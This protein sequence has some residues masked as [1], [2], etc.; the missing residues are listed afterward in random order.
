MRSLNF[1][2]PKIMGVINMTPDS[3]STNGRF[4][5]IDKAL[6][7]AQQMITDGV[8]I[9]DVGA[10]PTNPSLHPCVSLQEETDRLMPFLAKLC[11]NFDVPV[12]V[13][14]SKPEIMIEAIKQGVSIINDVRAFQREGAIAAV[15]DKNVMLCL[16]H[17]SY[18][19]G[20]PEGID[21]EN[22]NS[23]VT[24]K[25]KDFLAQR[26]EILEA[27]NIRRARLILD[28]GIGFGNFGKSTRDNLKLLNSIN[29]FK[30]FDLPVL[31]GVSR[32]TFIG[33]ILQNAPEDRLAGSIAAT[34]IAVYNGA[35]IIR[36]HD[37][38][39]TSEAVIIAEALRNERN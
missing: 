6:K 32:K 10:E 24:T 3:F 29:V 39:L 15:A 25:V 31:I 18:P 13:D 14:T 4:Q 23:D 30:D 1:R 16:M 33:D 34:A 5:N 28:P 38:K 27:A 9:I 2:S 8:D 11:Q 21:C 12:S 35:N 17:M 7:H 37:V 36:T 26:I 22:F 19:E 20:K